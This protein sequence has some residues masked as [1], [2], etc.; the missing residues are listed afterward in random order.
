MKTVCMRI[1]ADENISCA[2]EAFSTLGTVSTMPGRAMQPVDVRE[3]DVLLVRSVTHVG[4]EL[5][6]G[7]DVQ[8]VGSATIGTDHVDRAY[9]RER[10]IAFA[11]APASNADSV[12]DYVVA[13]LLHLAVRK[14]VRLR[15]QT[16]G[17]VGC[18]NIGGRLARRLSGL[19]LRVLCNDPPLAERAEA[20]GEPH[21]FTPLD[22]VLDSADIVTLHVPL[23]ETGPYATHHLFDAAALRRM[24]PGAWLLN[25]SRGAVVDNAALKAVLQEGSLAAAALDVWEH[26]PTPDVALLRR[27]DLATPHIAGYAYDGKICGTAMLYDALATHLGVPATWDPDPALRP[28]DGTPLVATPPDPALPRTDA[29]H[30][31]ARSMYDIAAED[32]RLRRIVDRPPA[33]RGAYFSRLRK[34]YPRRRTFSRFSTPGSAVSEALCSAIEQGLTVRMASIGGIH[35]PD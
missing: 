9:L 2:R 18:G 32:A 29:L 35:R 13:A 23:T 10:G 14:R 21:A 20:A 28:A 1:L 25:T 24:Q 3:A 27:V 17:I 30:H 8:F 12:A 16:V 15:R 7:S 31:V 33:A 22:T 5:L 11:H 26:E 6:D 19:G 34:E 4:P